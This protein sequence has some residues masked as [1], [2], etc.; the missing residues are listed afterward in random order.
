M[1]IKLLHSLFLKSTGVSTDT[2]SLKKGQLFFALKGDNFNGNIYAISALE[3]GASY[4][5]V[6]EDVD[7]TNAIKVENVLKTLQNLATY[8]R[9]YLGLPV[10]AITGSN[11]KTTTKELC[12]LAL[13]TKYNCFATHGNLNNHIGVPLSLLSLTKE[14][15]FAIIE[16]GANHVG[17]INSLCQITRPNYALITN[18]GKAHLEGFGSLSGVKK[19]KGELFR[20]IEEHG[21]GV[22]LNVDDLAVKSL[23]N[24]LTI[25]NS[26][27]LT[28]RPEITATKTNGAN[29]QVAFDLLIEGADKKAVKTQ[30]YGTYNLINVL[31]AI[32]IGKY[33]ECNLDSVIKAIGNYQPTN[34]RSEIRKIGS[35][36]F[37]L[38]AYNANPLSMQAALTD[39]ESVK[40]R[41]FAILGDMLELGS[42]KDEEHLQIVNRLSVME[43]CKAY[44]VGEIFESLKQNVKSFRVYPNVEELLKTISWSEFE[45]STVLIKGS[46]K[47]KLEKVVEFYSKESL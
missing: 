36:T 23:A 4:A 21:N 27:G 6:D 35:T 9:D 33:F 46:R 15:N 43:N 11:G 30:L 39:F 10:L 34:N 24:G 8:H 3:G 47:I 19:G 22:F 40:G 13:N 18:I 44:F 25:L 41:K 45:N 14:H 20:Y 42:S 37:I 2:R 16:M 17:E 5:V 28:S 12:N 29:M 38:D 7:S 32:T 26:Y 1:D 31:A